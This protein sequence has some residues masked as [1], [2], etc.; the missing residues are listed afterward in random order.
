MLLH[1][2]MTVFDAI[3]IHDRSWPAIVKLARKL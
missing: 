1:L 3:I 2:D